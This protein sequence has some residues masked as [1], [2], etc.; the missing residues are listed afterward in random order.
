LHSLP[1]SD[2]VAHGHDDKTVGCS[3]MLAKAS[4]NR[5][6]HRSTRDHSRAARSLRRGTKTIA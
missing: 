5:R 1:Q 4:V 2:E 6:Q 3:A